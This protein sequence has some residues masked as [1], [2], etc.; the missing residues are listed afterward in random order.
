MYCLELI[1]FDVSNTSYYV[2]VENGTLLHDIMEN[3][4]WRSWKFNGKSHI[5]FLGKKCGNPE[6]GLIFSSSV[7][8]GQSGQVARK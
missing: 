3:D 1:K 8:S 5:K 4:P 2:E 7:I 6:D